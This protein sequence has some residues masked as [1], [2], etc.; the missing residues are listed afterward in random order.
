VVG[1]KAVRIC[2]LYS[3]NQVWS[4]PAGPPNKSG[5]A[6]RVKGDVNDNRKIT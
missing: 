6:P 3:G 4:H 5:F 2:I 1:W